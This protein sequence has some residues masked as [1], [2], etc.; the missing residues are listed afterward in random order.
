MKPSYWQN[1]NFQFVEDLLKQ[2]PVDYQKSFR[3]ERERGYQLRRYW[4]IRD[5]IRLGHVK[6][7]IDDEELYFLPEDEIDSVPSQCGFV[8]FDRLASK[9]DWIIPVLTIGKVASMSICHALE[10]LPD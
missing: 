1:D 4:T 10:Q 8:D 6:K 7:L 9:G 5:G 3:L 2:M